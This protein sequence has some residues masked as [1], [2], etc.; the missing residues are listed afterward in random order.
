MKVKSLSQYACF[1]PFPM[2]KPSG[3]Q[4]LYICCVLG[5]FCLLLP[6]R[7]AFPFCVAQVQVLEGAAAAA[8]WDVRGKELSNALPAW[9][10]VTAVCFAL[11][12]IACWMV[13]PESH[14][15][16]SWPSI[17]LHGAVGESLCVCVCFSR[18]LINY[19]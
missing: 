1:A 18:E 2:Y 17:D 5:L 13:S 10:P 11:P 9:L 7:G 15:S 19:V 4:S 3:S 14:S 16:P 6:F 12:G 8:S